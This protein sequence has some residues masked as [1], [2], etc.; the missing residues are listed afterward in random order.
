MKLSLKL[1]SLPGSQEEQK[2]SPGRKETQEQPAQAEAA[3]TVE[4]PQ[5][6]HTTEPDTQKEKVHTSK[7]YINEPNE[8]RDNDTWRMTGC[9]MFFTKMA[10]ID[11]SSCTVLCSTGCVWTWSVA[12][13]VN[14][15]S[16]TVGFVCFWGSDLLRAHS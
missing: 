11:R 6:P 12:V 14:G 1:L 3:H 7:E 8:P 2:S 15:Q 13:R 9:S 16:L 4:T 10:D 5:Y